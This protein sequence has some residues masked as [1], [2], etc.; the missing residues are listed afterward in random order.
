MERDA[1]ASRSRRAALRARSG[2][3]LGTLRRSETAKAAALAG[4]MILANVVALGTTLAFGRLLNVE[5]Y[6]SLASLISGFLIL[7]VAGSALQAAVAREG[8]LGR[9]GRDGDLAATLGRWT[10]SL[11]LLL[12]VAVAVSI[13]A[14]HQ[15]ARAV[16]VD[17]EWAAAAELPAACLWL[18]LSV[19]RGILQALQRYST[20]GASMVFEQ[21]GRLVFGVLFIVAG[22][23]VT[24]AFLGTPVAMGMMAGVLWFHL[25]RQLGPER[26]DAPPH[27]LRE[28][29]R[30]GWVPV[31]ALTIIAVLQNIDVI[32][33]KHRLAEAA[34]GAYA[35]AAVAAKVVI[36]VAIGIG[37]HLLP[38]ATR[39][40]AEGDD[41]RPVLTRALA[42]IG[43]VSLPAL[44]IFAGVPHLL[45]ELAFGPKYAAG[46]DVLLILGGAMAL[47]AATY[48]AVQYLL[49][50]HH[51]TFLAGIA[52]I[53][54]AEPIV[55]VLAGG[56]TRTG[57]AWIVLATQVVAASLVL[58]PALRLRGVAPM[59]HAEAAPA[60]LTSLPG[61]D[62]EEGTIAPVADAG[63]TPAEV[64]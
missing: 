39:R 16:G 37:F 42:L 13:L 22:T 49:A 28:L 19:Q 8:A 34:A 2:D 50:V 55:L 7:S 18:L 56:Q 45:L 20:V 54:L 35:S 26:S 32:V 3:A 40:H 59:A 58:V 23:H 47:L 10:R 62:E 21:V 11:A 15:I 17:Q 12:V 44:L 57:L 51:T 6:G 64:R 41:A 24:G 29:F 43:V 1:G 38:E 60:P 53:A 27:R 52:A 33:A 31:A 4:A 61:I 25:H 30:R 48:L 14:R 36:W 46:S 63:E 9:L 5:Q